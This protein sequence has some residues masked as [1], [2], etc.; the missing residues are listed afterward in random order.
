MDRV[1]T[2]MEGGSDYVGSLY[3]AG[4]TS[5]ERSYLLS[6]WLYTHGD[7]PGPARRFFSI[8]ITKP[9]LKSGAGAQPVLLTQWL[10][11]ACCIFVL[12]I[13]T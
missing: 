6:Y 5:H 13:T 11:F 4:W 1:L 12:V 2:G 7:P 9:W 10:W 3:K 8:V